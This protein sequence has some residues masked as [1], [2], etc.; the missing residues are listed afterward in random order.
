MEQ[1]M[2][3]HLQKRL[4]LDA[5][6]PKSSSSV[7]RDVSPESH[8]IDI[9]KVSSSGF[10]PVSPESESGIAESASVKETNKGDLPRKDSST[11][12]F[13]M[14]SKTND[15]VIKPAAAFDD[16]EVEAKSKRP[17][18]SFVPPSA[19]E[20]TTASRSNSSNYPDLKAVANLSVAE[21][22]AIIKQIIERIPTNMEELFTY[23]ID[24]R[25]VDADLV[26]ER[27]KPW[28][29]KKI[30]EYLGEPEATLSKFICEQLLEHK[31]PAKMLS[32][33]ALVLEEEA[34]V[35]VAKM[36][37]L[38]I[39]AIAEKNLGLSM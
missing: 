22:K 5:K 29:D 2:Q 14:S 15:N 4:N 23:P 26:D 1:A 12:L 24:W 6:S 18:L 21:K 32:D 3:E 34:E 16:D 17:A 39:Y 38:L 25:A 9:P 36:W 37:R 20:K 8:S 35:F 31:P 10:R 7:S 33:I 30:V 11:F 13:S 28:V 19:S 27:I